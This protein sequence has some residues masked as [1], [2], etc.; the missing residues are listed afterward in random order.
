MNLVGAWENTNTAVRVWFS[1]TSGST[2][3]LSITSK[4]SAALSVF[5]DIASNFNS[6]AVTG[7]S[8]VI[9]FSGDRG[10]TNVGS[11]KS[12]KLYDGWL[13][14]HRLGEFR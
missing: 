3:Y 1:Q 5:S 8:P 14:F 7:T 13:Q 2:G 6:T 4:S 10:S 11:S 9:V 12:L